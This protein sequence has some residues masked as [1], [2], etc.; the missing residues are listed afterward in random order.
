L[1]RIEIVYV[2]NK[3]VKHWS[4]LC[5]QVVDLMLYADG[6]LVEVSVRIVSEALIGLETVQAVVIGNSI[7]Q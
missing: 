5:F 2:T 3:V 4:V 7:A 6:L 1:G